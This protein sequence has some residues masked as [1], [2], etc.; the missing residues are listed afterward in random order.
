MELSKKA[1]QHVGPQYTT[2]APL[3]CLPGS[4]FPETDWHH[5]HGCYPVSPLG[6]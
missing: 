5:T 1:M 6:L 4:P 2:A 3:G